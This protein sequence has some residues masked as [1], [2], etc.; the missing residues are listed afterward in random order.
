MIE[1]R[2]EELKAALQACLVVLP[3]SVGNGKDWD[4]C[5]DELSSESQGAVK[6]ARAQANAALAALQ[7]GS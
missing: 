5:W 2:V 3:D 7:S 4:W 6:A 1:Q